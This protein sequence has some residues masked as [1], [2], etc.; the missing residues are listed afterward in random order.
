MNEIDQRYVIKFLDTKK[1]V[2]DR[3][4]AELASVYEEQAYAK[5]AVKYWIHQVKLGKSDIEDE[6]KH[7]PPLDNVDARTLAGFSHEPFSLIRSIAQVLSS[8]PRQF[9]DTLPSPSTRNL[10]T[11]NKSLMH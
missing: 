3:I 9:V 8:R 4:V 2:P 11:S 1:F 6:S 5:K 7:G 10:D